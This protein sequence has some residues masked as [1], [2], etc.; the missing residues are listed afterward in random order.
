[1]LEIFNNLE[2]FFTDCYRRIN[3]REYARLSKIS[4]PSASKLLSSLEEEGLLSK[5]EDRRYVYYFA[6]KESKLFIE[7]SRIY[8]HLKIKETGLIEHLKLEL[9]NPLVL[10]F[11]SLSKAETTSSSDIDLAIFTVSKKK[12]NL[13]IYGEKIGRNIQVFV[14]KTRDHVSNKELLNNILNGF[15]LL[16]SW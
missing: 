16:G 11:G 12:I 13:K 15:V 9:V 1:M 10:L 4:P 7:L 2:L 8:W 3:V 6:N 14:F 5:E